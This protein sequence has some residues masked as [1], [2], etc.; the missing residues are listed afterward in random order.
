MLERRHFIITLDGSEWTW[1]SVSRGLVKSR[2]C[3]LSG[4]RE[5][6]VET[7]VQEGME[8]VWYQFQ[9]GGKTMVQNIFYFP[10][11]ATTKPVASCKRHFKIQLPIGSPTATKT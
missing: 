9:D 4:G 2:A 10:N 11:L 1:E 7:K 8:R 6:Y 3:I 5:L